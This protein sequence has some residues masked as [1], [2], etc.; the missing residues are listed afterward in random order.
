MYSRLEIFELSPIV[1]SSVYP[2][3]VQFFALSPF[4]ECHRLIGITI[5]HCQSLIAATATDGSRLYRSR[6][7]SEASAYCA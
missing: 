5:I 1:N 4:P 6:L 2:Y 7:Q 3:Y